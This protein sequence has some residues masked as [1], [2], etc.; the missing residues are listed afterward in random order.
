ME[1]CSSTP[2]SAGSL[3][4]RSDYIIGVHK[5]SGPASYPRD[6]GIFLGLLPDILVLI[7]MIILKNYL[8]KVGVWNF[9]INKSNI[10]KTPAFKCKTNELSQREQLNKIDKS[11]YKIYLFE[12][13]SLLGKI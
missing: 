7:S 12:R 10:Y 1:E 4:T 13:A 9:V 5:Y 3:L 11:N 2:V 6:Q 8:V